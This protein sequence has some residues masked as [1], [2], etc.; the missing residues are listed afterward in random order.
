MMCAAASCGVVSTC[1]SAETSPA[2]DF[3][4][5]NIVPFSPGREVE[6][7]ANARE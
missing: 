5:Y 3:A 2:A 7:A 1:L 4:L 6:A